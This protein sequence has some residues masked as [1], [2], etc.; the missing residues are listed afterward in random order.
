MLDMMLVRLDTIQ[1]EFTGQGHG[2]KFMV[3]GGN[4]NSATAGISDILTGMVNS[5]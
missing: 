1:V 4:K 3:T 2:S 5:S